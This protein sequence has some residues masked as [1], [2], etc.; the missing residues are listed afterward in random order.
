ME[1][2]KFNVHSVDNSATEV[3][4]PLQ[5]YM[6]TSKLLAQLYYCSLRPFRFHCRELRFLSRAWWKFQCNRI[7]RIH[8]VDHI[9]PV[10]TDAVRFI[11]NVQSKFDV[12]IRYQKRTKDPYKSAVRIFYYIQFLNVA[13]VLILTKVHKITHKFLVNSLSHSKILN[14]CMNFEIVYYHI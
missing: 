7:F 2:G 3:T 8:L 4:G 5:N 13:Q 6:K 14:N 9:D 10:R 12:G 1:V 11:A